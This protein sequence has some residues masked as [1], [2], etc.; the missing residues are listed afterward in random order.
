MPEWLMLLVLAL[1]VVAVWSVAFAVGRHCGEKA[2]ID[3]IVYL[4]VSHASRE[5]ETIEEGEE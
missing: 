5:G 1:V 2:I 4:V 3:A